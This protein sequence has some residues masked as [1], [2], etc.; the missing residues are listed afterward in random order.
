MVILGRRAIVFGE[1][2]LSVWEPRFHLQKLILSCV[3]FNKRR[4]GRNQRSGVSTHY[5][6]RRS[7]AAALLTLTVWD[8]HP[9]LHSNILN[10]RA[11]LSLQAV[12][13]NDVYALELDGG[14][15][16]ASWSSIQCSG[17]APEVRW[18]HVA[19]AIDEEKMIVFGGIGNKTKRLND[20]WVLDVAP[21]IPVWAE[22]TVIGDVPCP[23][24]HHSGTMVDNQ[25]VLCEQ[26]SA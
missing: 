16:T 3:V 18:R 20:V 9:R 22:K 15:D 5:S 14:G 10:R 17:I 8:Q 1:K 11:D 25:V 7:I 26:L 13:L 2:I 24:G 21:D 4:Y 12:Q 23:R 19:A 6:K